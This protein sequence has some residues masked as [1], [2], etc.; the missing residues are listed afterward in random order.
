MSHIEFVMDSA[1]MI[2]TPWRVMGANLQ[3]FFNFDLDER[4]FKEYVTRHVRGRLEANRRK[5]IGLANGR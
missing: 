5:K 3:D 1:E 4:Q 2:D